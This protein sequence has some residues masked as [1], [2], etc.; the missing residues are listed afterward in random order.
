MPTHM[1]WRHLLC[2]ALLLTGSGNPAL[3]A[4]DPARSRPLR[5]DDLL[6]WEDLGDDFSPRAFISPSGESIAYRRMRPA[7]SRHSF[8]TQIWSLER[9]GMDVWLYSRARGSFNL[10]QGDGDDSTWWSPKWSPSG[11][12]LGLL[13]NRHER[14]GIW[15]YDTSQERLAE[16]SLPDESISPDRF[17]WLDE[18][19][20]LVV[21][22]V[23]D[24]NR[25]QTVE[26]ARKGWDRFDRGLPTA[27]PRGA[28]VEPLDSNAGGLAILDVRKNAWRALH[29]ANNGRKPVGAFIAPGKR[30][31]ACSYFGAELP[32][33][34]GTQLSF[35]AQSSFR[36][37]VI[38]LD[39]GKAQPLIEA[40]SPSLF[41]RKVEWSA[42]G[43]RLAYWN[44]TSA[45]RWQLCEAAPSNGAKTELN[46]T[47][48]LLDDN[49]IQLVW[50][51]GTQLWISARTQA[52]QPAAWWALRPDGSPVPAQ[53]PEG[54]NRVWSAGGGRSLAA[55]SNE[56]FLA[57]RGEQKLLA[58]FS[59]GSVEGITFSQASGFVQKKCLVQLRSAGG[60]VEFKAIDLDS[61]EI[62]CVSA[63]S[64]GGKLEAFG[65]SP[66]RD[67]I[68]V[69]STSVPAA[70]L[71]ECTSTGR[72][73]L[74]EANRAY[75]AG[76]ALPKLQLVQYTSEEGKSLFGVLMA[77]AD[78]AE[79]RRAPLVVEIYPGA[80]FSGRPG[81]FEAFGRDRYMGA[82]K[83]FQS[84]AVLVG[85]GF[86]VLVPSIPLSDWGKADDGLLK[87]RG[88]VLPA[89]AA[90]AKT[91]LVD[92]GRVFL[93]GHSHGGYGTN[94]LVGLT[95]RFSAAV[96]SAGVA[97]SVSAYLSAPN[98]LYTNSA[99]VST[100]TFWSFEQG[101]Q[102]M[103]SPPWSD[104]SRYLRNSP[105]MYVERVKT[106][107]LLLHGDID[108]NVSVHQSVEMFQ[109]LSRLGK[110]VEFVPYWGEGHLF[111]SPANIRDR[112]ARI[113]RWFDDFGDMARDG[114]G[115]FIWE[116]AT[117]KSRSG[118]SCPKLQRYFSYERLFAQ[119][120]PP[121]SNQ[122]Q[123]TG[124]A[125]SMTE[126]LQP[127]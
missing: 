86:A 108:A 123:S 64:K 13:S 62:T 58:R 1:D 114:S 50:E 17:A 51:S 101:Q 117:V 5:V 95:E 113:I 35:G 61:A 40:G 48:L 19:R 37:E 116:G 16:L 96:S 100:S 98:F 11:K 81:E 70:Q 97:D 71:W 8:R 105:I 109:A 66:T 75:L 52:G 15:Y 21:Y 6:A 56:L 83:A 38:D 91:G 102:A 4:E 3:R 41:R 92:A 63:P 84:A 93:F 69:V 79:S 110:S 80:V 57:D 77:P 31:I 20:L 72:T 25:W 90:A 94:G 103:G 112:W 24:I 88:S 111:V 42:D 126:N 32:L 107:L 124:E 10:T 9:K 26:V 18:E 22:A 87:I 23:N 55:T 121:E 74:A 65:E 127:Q 104:S 49:D 82:G 99:A 2:L 125:R 44:Q 67:P 68:A 122:S 34:A 54:C 29:R 12:R 14:L 28:Q 39:T 46:T 7:S 30:H 89:V 73:L 115:N 53:L 60:E 120:L 36:L 78:A 45:G 27:A 85:A 119:N 106:P 76:V 59:R 43:S 118:E 33:A 47:S